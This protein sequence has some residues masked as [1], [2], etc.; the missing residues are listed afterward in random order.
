MGVRADSFPSLDQL[1]T[2][3]YAMIHFTRNRDEKSGPPFV[4]CLGTLEMH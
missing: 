2:L 4:N 3:E 1:L